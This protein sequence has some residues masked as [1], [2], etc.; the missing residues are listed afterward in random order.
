V[1]S[2]TAYADTTAYE[3]GVKFRSDIDGFITG[4]RFYK[5]TLNTGAHLG[6]LWTSTG[7]MLGEAM[8]TNETASGWQTASFATPIPIK[9][10]TT[11]IASYWDPNGYYAL[12]RPFFTSG[13]DSLNL[14]ALAD[15][16]DGP[17]GVFSPRAMAFP[18]RSVQQ[19]NYWVDVVFTP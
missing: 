13:V 8:F 17:N 7:T 10:N 11:Y 2:E 18:T 9:A 14:H 16:V 1:P 19:A 5:G 3:L 4:I 12:D 15:G 6:H